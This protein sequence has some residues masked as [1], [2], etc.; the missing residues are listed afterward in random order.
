MKQG[1]SF[2][3]STV[4]IMVVVSII[5]ILSTISIYGLSEVRAKSRDAERQAEL[6]LLEGAVER[7]KMKYGEYPTGCNGA[8]EWSA[9]TVDN[10]SSHK[11]TSGGQYII[12]LAPEFIPVLPVDP[13]PNGSNSGYM[14]YSNS[15]GTA[16]KLV[17]YN[18]VEAEVD[19]ARTKFEACDRSNV[20]AGFT[21]S[22]GEASCVSAEADASYAV[23][24]GYPK[25]TVVGSSANE[26]AV[27]CR[28]P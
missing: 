19:S 4:E 5:G 18:S 20:C 24:G 12:G 27:I 11:C 2:G 15:D 10:D 3:F 7:Y 21:P 16:Y 6:R 9:Q 14:Y 22:E 25:E 23:W 8:N 26:A 13:N 28:L 1:R 17:V